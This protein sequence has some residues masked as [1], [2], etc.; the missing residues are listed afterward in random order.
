MS[1]MISLQAPVPV[2]NVITSPVVSV[3]SSPSVPASTNAVPP[4]KKAGISSAP[5]C[6]DV[7][8]CQEMY[9]KT[10]TEAHVDICSEKS[11]SV[12]C[13]TFT[14]YV[15]RENFSREGKKVF[16]VRRSN[17]VKDVLAKYKLFF[18][19]GITPIHVKFVEDPNAIDAGGPLREMFTLF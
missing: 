11:N 3:S 9:I 2:R 7:I 19:D 13:S 18:R 12:S 16:N 5:A 6:P 17:L 14:S 15:E 8:H 1:S 4:P 10:D